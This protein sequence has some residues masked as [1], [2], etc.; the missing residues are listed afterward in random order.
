[1]IRSWFFRDTPSHSDACRVPHPCGEAGI[2]FFS[3]EARVGLDERDPDI[4]FHRGEFEIIF[5]HP[6][7]KREGWCT[8]LPTSFVSRPVF[9]DVRNLGAQF[10]F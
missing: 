4:V 9:L 10:F 2:C 3:F 7:Q 1:M 8:R 5:S 6:S